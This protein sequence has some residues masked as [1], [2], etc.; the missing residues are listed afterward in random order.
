MANT[1][2]SNETNENRRIIA[3]IGLGL[4]G[5]S[6]ALALKKTGKYFIT[7][8]SRSAE[9]RR[10]AL[11]ACAVDY[12]ADSVAEAVRDAD[13]SFFCAPPEAVIEEIQANAAFFKAG[14]AVSEVCGVKERVFRDITAALPAGVDYVGIHPMAGKERGGFANADEGLYRDAGFIMTYGENCRAGSEKAVEEVIR[15]LGS[16][17]I[18]RNTPA[19]HDAIIA[20]TSD[21]M[22]ISAAA[23][24]RSYAGDMTPAH[25]AGAFRDC[26][27]IA[28][29][30][31]GL[32][33]ELLMMNSPHVL[34][35]LER[36]IR[37]LA[38]FRDAL[39]RGDEKAMYDFLKTAGDNKRRMKSLR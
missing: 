6:M 29:I 39:E 32:W 28:D 21:L 27:R 17:R 35:V 2:E 30:D 19:R 13:I 4:M 16:E 18:V 20:Y 9:T 7:G 1:G 37:D 22:H 24:C 8:Y 15:D 36:Y 12:M 5:G 3:I 26:T 34:P 10:Q 25:T 11:E 33:T 23:L 31:A 14:S 38:D